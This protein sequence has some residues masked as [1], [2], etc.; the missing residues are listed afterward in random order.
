MDLKFPRVKCKRLGPLDS[1]FILFMVEL[2]NVSLGNIWRL[3]YRKSVPYSSGLPRLKQLMKDADTLSIDYLMLAREASIGEFPT[4]LEDYVFSKLDSIYQDSIRPYTEI[5][6]KLETIYN[7]TFSSYSL[8]SQNSYG[9]C[10]IDRTDLDLISSEINKNKLF[11]R[12][13]EEKYLYVKQKL[14]NADDLLEYEDG[15]ENV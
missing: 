15:I 12:A 6:S 5:I 9:P 1:I 4:E 8:C 13:I 10:L 7:K 11:I 3:Y 14:E 2:D